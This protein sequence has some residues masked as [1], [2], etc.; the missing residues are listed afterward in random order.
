MKIVGSYEAKAKLS[1]ILREVESG[2]TVIITRN[3]H[4]I[5]KISPIGEQAKRD[6]GAAMARLLASKATLGR[7]TLQEL[8]DAGRR[9]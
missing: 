5:A 8:R 4:A 9:R 2:E 3:G 1:G 7:H 6:P